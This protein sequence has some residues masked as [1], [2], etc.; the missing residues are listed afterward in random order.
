MIAVSNA[1]NSESTTRVSILSMVALR[2]EPVSPFVSPSTEM[3]TKEVGDVD[4]KCFGNA[5]KSPDSSK[6]PPALTSHTPG[7][8]TR[9]SMSQLETE[10]PKL[11]S[12]DAS[13]IA[14][15]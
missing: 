15:A 4:G 14:T 6:H 10:R 9:H 13:Y 2:L 11:V 5:G 8:A 7:D 12:C 1:C 3:A